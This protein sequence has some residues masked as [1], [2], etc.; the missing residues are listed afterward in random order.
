MSLP[1]TR[2][3]PCIGRLADDDLTRLNRALLVALGLAR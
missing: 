3:G 1:R 2:L